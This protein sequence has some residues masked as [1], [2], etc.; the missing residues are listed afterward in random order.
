MYN[1]KHK[2]DE[3]IHGQILIYNINITN[4]SQ[5]GYDIRSN[6][7]SATMWW[8]QPFWS[9]KEEQYM[10]PMPK[11]Q[12]MSVAPK[13]M[14]P[15]VSIPQN[16]PVQVW[17]WSIAPQWPSMIKQ[18]PWQPIGADITKQKVT[19]QRQQYQSF[20]KKWGQAKPPAEQR[21]DPF[22]KTID[23]IKSKVPQEKLVGLTDEAILKKVYEE[24]PNFRA[25]FEETLKNTP[26]Q[27]N[28]V[29]WWYNLTLKPKDQIKQLQD[30][31]ILKD[32]HKADIEQKSVWE[33]L[34]IDNSKIQDNM[35]RLTAKMSLNPSAV[36][37]SWTTREDKVDMIKDQVEYFG[38][39]L[40]NAWPAVWNTFM[41]IV[42]WIKEISKSLVSDPKWTANAVVDSVKMLIDNPEQIP[43]IISKNPIDAIFIAEWIT[44]I[45]RLLKNVKSLPKSTQGFI[46]QSK[47]FLDDM[48]AWGWAMTDDFVN[49]W[50]ETAAEVA[51]RDVK[52][53]EELAKAKDISDAAKAAE[54][55]KPTKA[56]MMIERTHKFTDSEIRKYEAKFWETPWQTLNNRWLIAG[57]DETLKVSLDD[58]VKYQ[59]Q[60]SEW[61]SKIQKKIP[62]DDD[63]IQMAKEVAEHEK[64]VMTPEQIKSN[65]GKAWDDLVA[66][67]ENWELT[68]VE[69]EKIKKTFESKKSLKYDA[70]RTSVEQERLKN[71][72]SAIRNKQ[73]KW[74]EEAWFDNIK[75]INKEISKSKAI[76]D[77][78][79]KD[80]EKIGWLWLSDYVLLA[81]ATIEPATLTLLLAKKVAQTNWF[82]RNMINVL[83]KINGRATQAD[84]VADLKKIQQISNETQLQEFLKGWELKQPALPYKAWVTPGEW[85]VIDTKKITVTP[86]WQ[87]V[88]EWQI[89]EINKPKNASTSSN[90]LDNRG[91][92]VKATKIETGEPKWITKKADIEVNEALKPKVEPTAKWVKQAVEKKAEPLTTKQEKQLSNVDESMLKVKKTK[93]TKPLAVNKGILK[94]DLSKSDFEDLSQFTEKKWW[95]WYVRDMDSLVEEVEYINKRITDSK[96]WLKKHWNMTDKEL[97]LELKKENIYWSKFK[98]VQIWDDTF[99]W[100]KQQYKKIVDE[101]T[102]FANQ[103]KVTKESLLSEYK[104]DPDVIEFRK[105]KEKIYADIDSIKSFDDLWK[106]MKKWE[107]RFWPTYKWEVDWIMISVEKWKYEYSIKIWWNNERQQ[108]SYNV[109]AKNIEQVKWLIRR[110]ET[111]DARA[112]DKM[113]DD[114][115][116]TKD[117]SWDERQKWLTPKKL[118]QSE[119]KWE[120][121][122]MVKAPEK[123][124]K[125]ST[126]DE[127]LEYAKKNIETLKQKYKN[128]KKNLTKDWTLIINTDEVR[129]LLWAD[130]RID[131]KVNHAW[132]SFIAKELRKDALASAKPW[133]KVLI[134]WWWGWSGK[135]FTLDNVINPKWYWRI[136]DMTFSKLDNI[137]YYKDMVSKWLKPEIKFV[138]SPQDVAWKNTLDR[139]LWKEIQWEIWRKLPFDP[140]SEAHI[141]V[142]DNMKQLTKE[143]IPFEVFVNRWEWKWLPVKINSSDIFNEV[144]KNKN[145]TKAEARAI[146]EKFSL[147]WTKLNKAQI[148]SLFSLFILFGIWSAI[149]S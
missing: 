40:L 30:D 97:L 42:P 70:T 37:A 99:N 104:N 111:K 72:D 148:T 91:L 31:W 62:V 15:K 114:F 109:W 84:K 136:D 141:W 1:Q 112:L 25:K 26:Y 119:T 81:W 61:L 11:Q 113:T 144:K 43:E 7:K 142:V 50:K 140:F 2:L 8:L 16:I 5:I 19:E 14:T 47:W 98:N 27:I 46:E 120:L 115:V 71:L 24:T 55:A 110:M 79:A 128:T 41:D 77:L 13:G 33:E 53:T 126:S 17:W 65:K 12:M 149:V 125:T 29:E 48:K 143:N 23:Q 103:D 92:W 57:W 49:A 69:L 68:H 36:Y 87:A 74:A 121:K 59:K 133:T 39:Y 56:D 52:I 134:L 132:S 60:K 32:E 138:Y 100:A 6:I 102:T 51:K 101:R 67:A 80:V 44:Q 45:P 86:E 122:A 20:D 88:R 129:P 130:L 107:N 35:D 54:R 83:N 146:A 135:W 78:L 85:K 63:V 118:P 3:E 105:W 127:I 147:E 145:L 4:M 94:K 90:N 18:I 89:L 21:Y 117:M 73:Q 34:K 93:E 38:N 124:N 131:A 137:Q 96:D 106:I 22:K 76:S 10:T 123:I 9:K 95:M 139:F 108:W 75:D 66:K 58:M 116:K 28:E 82:R 64:S